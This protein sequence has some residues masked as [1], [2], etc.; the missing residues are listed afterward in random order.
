MAS[1]DISKYTSMKPKSFKL[2]E[3]IQMI[4]CIL[5]LCPGEDLWDEILTTLEV[6]FCVIIYIFG[7]SRGGH[8]IIIQ[9]FTFM[10]LAKTQ[11][12]VRYQYFVLGFPRPLTPH[13]D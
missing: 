6:F 1:P 11:T 9:Y 3:R 4:T 12:R 5:L 8:R 13:G 2:L 10:F 7:T